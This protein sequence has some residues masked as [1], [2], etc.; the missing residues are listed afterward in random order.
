MFKTFNTFRHLFDQCVYHR[1][2]SDGMACAAIVK[3]VCPTVEFIELAA[4]QDLDEDPSIFSN[5]NVIFVDV[6]P[7]PEYFRKVIH[8]AERVV[9]I[10]HHITYRTSIETVINELKE[11]DKNKDEDD[12][13]DEKIELHF[14]VNKAACQ[15]TFEYFYPAQELPWFLNYIA[16]RDLWK[17]EMP[18][19]KEITNALY[20]DYHTRSIDNIL[21]LFQIKGKELERLQEYLLKK[22]KIL[23]ELRT[24]AVKSGCRNRLECTYTSPL[25]DAYRVW[26]YTCDQYLLSDVGA[27][28]TRYRFKDGK[29][30]DFVV[31]WWY[32]VEHHQFGLSFRSDNTSP[33]STD[34]EQIARMIQERGGGHRNAAGC[35]VDGSTVLRDLFVPVTNKDDDEKDE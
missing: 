25:G 33:T 4:G 12:N 11:D 9:V 24:E 35:V 18:H 7:S 3:T 32:D 8:V 26:L 31:Y 10:D 22:G 27:R 2:C 13:E 20:T 19:S 1:G 17:Y 23:T 21:R 5:R 15:L 16:D 29:Y 28:L 6:V 34:V 30:P 14:D